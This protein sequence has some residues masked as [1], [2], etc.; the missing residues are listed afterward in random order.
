[1]HSWKLPTVGDGGVGNNGEGR[2]EDVEDALIKQTRNV[3][4]VCFIRV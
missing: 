4:A 3:F 1:M 2:V